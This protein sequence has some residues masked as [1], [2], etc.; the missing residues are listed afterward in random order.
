MSFV[1]TMPAGIRMQGDPTGGAPSSS[2]SAAPSLR[3]RPGGVQA[4]GAGASQTGLAVGDRIAA[5]LDGDAGG[6]DFADAHAG[7]R[8]HDLSAIGTVS[9]GRPPSPYIGLGT[10]V[11]GW[12]VAFGAA[13]AQHLFW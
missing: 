12:W 1:D 7:T 5:D 3:R 2:S 8:G 11:A 6:G 9:R 13:V 10:V 4:R